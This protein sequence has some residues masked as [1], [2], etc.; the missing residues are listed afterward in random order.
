MV[1][2]IGLYLTTCAIINAF[3]VPTPEA[4]APGPSR[5]PVERYCHDETVDGVSVTNVAM[6]LA[7]ATGYWWCGACPA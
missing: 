2:L 3:E 6:C 1:M 7:L 4:M 5:R